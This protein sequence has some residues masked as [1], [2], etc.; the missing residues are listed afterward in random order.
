MRAA[1]AMTPTLM[2]AL[3]E[4]CVK[5]AKRSAVAFVAS[6]GVLGG[7][8]SQLESTWETSLTVA[9]TEGRVRYAPA[10]AVPWPSKTEIPRRSSGEKAAESVSPMLLKEDWKGR[11]LMVAPV[12]PVIELFVMFA[13]SSVIVEGGMERSKPYVKFMSESTW[14]LITKFGLKIGPTAATPGI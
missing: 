12:K 2:F 5:L 4:R 11:A 13:T 10:P 14:K 8:G 6:A 9:E 1:S 3:A 7:A